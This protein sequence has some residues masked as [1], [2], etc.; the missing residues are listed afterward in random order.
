MFVWKKR[1]EKKMCFLS[2][3]REIL[4][5]GENANNYRI[6]F[7]N[8]CLWAFHA[9]LRALRTFPSDEKLSRNVHRVIE[10]IRVP[11][12]ASVSLSQRVI[13]QVVDLRFHAF[14]WR[15][16]D[17]YATSSFSSASWT[18]IFPPQPHRHEAMIHNTEWRDVLSHAI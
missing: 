15:P 10:F 18:R 11:G 3:R 16:T 12:K 7:R 8:K 2:S 6:P 13:E 9:T 5:W 1:F 14:T 4:R 17:P